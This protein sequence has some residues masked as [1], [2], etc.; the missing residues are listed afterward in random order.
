MTAGMEKQLSAAAADNGGGSG[1]GA[2]TQDE[3]DTTLTVP[4]AADDGSGCGRGRATEDDDDAILP[5]PE[6]ADDSGEGGGGAATEDDGDVILP[7]PAAADDGGRGG[8][9][10]ATEDAEDSVLPEA[11]AADDG[12]GSNGMGGLS[13]SLPSNVRRTCCRLPNVNWRGRWIIAGPVDDPLNVDPLQFSSAVIVESLPTFTSREVYVRAV[14]IMAKMRM[15]PSVTAAYR[16]VAHVSNSS[17]DSALGF[18]EPSWSGVGATD[19][20][21]IPVRRILD[22]AAAALRNPDRRVANGFVLFVSAVAPSIHPWHV[23]QTKQVRRQDER[24]G[25]VA[26]RR[27]LTQMTDDE[28][29]RFLRAGNCSTFSSIRQATT[30][31]PRT[32]A[33]KAR[34]LRPTKK[35][36]W[37]GRAAPDN[38]PTRNRLVGMMRRVFER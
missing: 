22:R 32:P 23:Y 28:E 35:R 5:V 12:G 20:V 8:G 16:S 27:A 37:R 26:Y 31:T 4:A 19:D 9:G 21:D 36:P 29:R 14:P 33:E 18:F 10:G 3:D 17:G 34:R 13:S 2:T 6:A 38:I 7:V 11:P 24:R 25:A 30:Y 15:Y 1:G